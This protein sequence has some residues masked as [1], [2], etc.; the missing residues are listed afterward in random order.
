MPE[1]TGQGG[2]INLGSIVNKLIPL[3]VVALVALVWRLNDRVTKLESPETV[4]TRVANL[5]AALM[6]VLIKYG[7]DSG[8]AERGVDLATRAEPSATPEP[9]VGPPVTS[10][11][12]E[13]ATEWARN[14][15]YEQRALPPDA[16]RKD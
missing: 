6:P 3:A 16:R 12:D 10:P 7:I 8:L 14:Q 15:I 5:E 13:T 2:W 9:Q 11:P 4:Q 1:N